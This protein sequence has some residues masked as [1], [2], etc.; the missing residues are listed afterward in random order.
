MKKLGETLLI[1]EELLKLYSPISKNVGIDR[2]FPFIHLAQPYYIQPI[3][4]RPLMEELQHQIEEDTLTEENK[5][6]VLKIAMPL[7]MWTTYLAV[8]GLGYSFT[9]KGVTKEKSENSDSLNEKEMAEYMLSLKNQAEMAQELLISY[10][11]NCRDLYP[12]WKPQVECNCEKYMPTDGTNKVEYKTLIYFPKKQSKCGCG[13]TPCES[14]KEHN[15][16]DVDVNNTT[17]V[18]KE[19]KSFDCLSQVTDFEDSGST[20]NITETFPRQI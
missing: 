17:L 8:R 16:T 9:Q 11:C 19:W 12:L 2:I 10:L 1:S 14:C 7:A 6:L 20:M 3:L 5:A 18:V 4:G 13:K 15:V